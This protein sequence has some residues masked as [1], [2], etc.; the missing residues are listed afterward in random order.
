MLETLG[1]LGGGVFLAEALRSHW[2]L[3]R[4]IQRRQDPPRR[5]SYPSISVIRPIKGLDAG[6]EENL[7]SAFDHGYPGEV[8]IFF[9][10]DGPEEPAVPLAEKILAEYR[11]AGGTDRAEIVFCGPPPAHQTGKVNAMRVGLEKAR[12]ELVAFVDSDVRSDRDALRVTVDTLLGTPRAGCAFAPVRVWGAETVGDVS[13]AMLLNGVY[14]PWSDQ[15]LRRRGGDLPFI[16]GQFMVLTR[17]GLAATGNLQ[18]LDG[19]LVDDLFMGELLQRKGFRNVPSTHPVRIIQSGLNWPDSV[20]TYIRWI[21]F[22]R[23]GIPSWA[24]KIPIA[25]RFA[26]FWLALLAAPLLWLSGNSLAALLC[27]LAMLTINVSF[28]RLSEQVGGPDIAPRHWLVPAIVILIAPWVYARVL[29]QRTV[30]WRGRVYQL[31]RSARL[32]SV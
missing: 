17:E 6:A 31:D 32:D 22:S 16:L 27:L 23:T 7:R 9:I 21:T 8:E 4:D 19:Q 29:L 18:G 11:A 13:Y 25:L 3:R 26:I 15:L 14:A 10:F 2:Q 1:L 28:V 20:A 24:I 30:N 5:E 12:G